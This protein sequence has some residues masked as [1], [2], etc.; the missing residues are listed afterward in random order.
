MTIGARRGGLI[1][2]RF[3]IVVVTA[4]FILTYPINIGQYDAVGYLS[5]ILAHRSNLIMASGYP[6][7]FYYL[8]SLCTTLPPHQALES[9]L[10]LT[11]VE[12]GLPT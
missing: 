8:L 4:L 7:L 5:M 12:N 9:T 3:L 11:A 1:A 10:A 2:F 6:F